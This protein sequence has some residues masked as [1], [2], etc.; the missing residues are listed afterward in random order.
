MFNVICVG[1]GWVYLVMA[2]N[3]LPASIQNVWR[4]NTGT[5]GRPGGKTYGATYAANPIVA[6]P[7][8][9]PMLPRPTPVVNL[10]S[11]LHTRLQLRQRLS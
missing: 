2:L 10:G 8:S 4:V 11:I 6:V 1:Y 5:G 9:L 7:F 3:T